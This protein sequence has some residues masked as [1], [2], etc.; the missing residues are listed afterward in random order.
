MPPTIQVLNGK[1]VGK[2]FDLTQP[3]LRMGRHPECEIPIDLNSVSRFHANILKEGDEYVIDDLQSRN[4]TFVNGRKIEGPTVLKDNDRIKVCDILFVYRKL[5]AHGPAPTVNAVEDEGKSTVVS[6]LDADGS[7]SGVMVVQAEAKLKAII[8]I[9]HAIGQTLDPDALFP[10][11]LDSLFKIFPQADRGLIILAEKDGALIPRCTKHRRGNEDTVR[12]S[13][14]IVQQ[15]MTQKQAILSADASNDD[16]FS[17]AQ[18]IAD[19]RIRSIMCVP[20][21]GTDQRALGVIQLDT[22][23]YHQQFNMEDLQIL[24]SVASQAAFAVENAEMHSEI[25]GQERIQRELGFARDV[26]A[27]FLPQSM[28]K[29]EG[30]NF[31][32]Y[33][34]AAGMVGG[35]YYDFLKLPNGSQAVIVGDVSGK[36]VPA[37]LFMARVTS[38]ARVALLMNP[39]KPADAMAAINNAICGAAIPD[40]F[41]TLAICLIEPEGKKM[42]IVNAGHMSPVIRRSDGK[43]DEPAGEGI[44]G[45]PIG[46]LED[47]SYESIE[48]EILPNND[49]VLYSDG[50][51]EAM[52]SAQ[53]QYGMDRLRNKIKQLNVPPSQLGEA[54]VRDVNE[55]VAGY[56][57]SDDMTLV[58]F[59]R[60]K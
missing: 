31:W 8:E 1:Q 60:G 23:S 49:V 21:V 40:K 25:L 41:I 12:F 26:Q 13:K 34:E 6:T 27:G 53:N 51:N 56:K 38:E 45:L 47:F 54:I 14:T 30:Y 18:S 15:A 37:A 24:V 28:P 22:Q 19:F 57:Q 44:T 35:D 11:I 48:V 10:K 36:G 58:V 17:M 55:H 39:E 46:V 20:L 33:Y 52:D 29:F 16:R 4:G 32:A 9:S 2:K 42:V 43:L 59:S 3:Q 5:P 7:R 50:I